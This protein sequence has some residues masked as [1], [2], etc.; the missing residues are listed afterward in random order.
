MEAALLGVRRGFQGPRPPPFFPVFLSMIEL[1]SPAVPAQAPNPQP[2]RPA[3]RKDPGIADL[4]RRRRR[5]RLAR[6]IAG[7]AIAI[8][9]LVLSVLAGI[10]ERFAAETLTPVFRV[11][12]IT[13]ACVA[14]LLPILFFGHPKRKS[15]F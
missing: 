5:V 9:V 12:P 2:G 11:L 14:A 15:R 7:E 10:S 4:V 6:F 1:H 8:A 3:A 13:A